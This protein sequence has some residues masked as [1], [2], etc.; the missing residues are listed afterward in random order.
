MKKIFASL[1]ILFLAVSV[2]GTTR[3]AQA[4]SAVWLVLP[5]RQ[6]KVDASVSN[7][8]GHLASD[9]AITVIVTLNKQADLSRVNGA[10]RAARQQG[11]LQALQA[12]SN[13]TQGQLKKLLD[14]RK[15]QGS[16][17]KYVSFWV[18]NGFSVTAT[19]DVINELAQQPDVYS[20]TS[21]DLQIIPTTYGN[22]EP[23]IS[24]V[25]AP[26]LWS[27]GYTGQGVVVASMDSGVDVSQPDLSGRWRGGS[28]SWYDPYNQH[29]TTPYDKSGHGTWTTGIMV[30]GNAGGT[31]V[32]VAPDAKWIAVK[33]FNDAGSSTTTAIHQGFQW[34]LDPDGNPAT[35]DAPDVVNNSW[36][37]ATPGCY[38]DFEPDLQS[39]RTAG[40]LPVF[41]A[42]NG[43]PSANTSY[44]PSNNP[45][46]FAVGA[47][48]NT[49]QIYGY[50][51]RGPSACGGSTGPY[52]EIVA[53]GVNIH[54]T[55]LGS[56]YYNDS[57]TSFAA[58]HVAGGL[59]LLLSAYPNLSA[60]DQA[61]ALMSSALDLGASGP[62]D[63]FGYGLMNLSAAL[64]WISSNPA[65]VNLALNKPVTVSTYQDS[66]HNGAMAVD[67]NQTTQWQTV[68]V[69]GKNPVKT[70]S[71]EVD[72]GSIQNVSRVVLKWD[73]YYATTYNVQVSTNRTTWSTV[74]NTSVG[75][76]GDNTATFNT[77]QARYVRMNS[78]VWNNSTNRNWL[79]E[80]EIYAG[81]STALADTPAP[82]SE[83][84]PTPS[85]TPAPANSVHVG[86]LDANPAANGARWN[87]TVIV[88][89]HDTFEAPLQGAVVSGAWSNGATGNGSC[90]TGADGTCSI[91][92]SALKTSVSNVT[93][94]V[95]NLSSGFSYQS[96][97]NHDPDGDSNGTVIVVS[98]P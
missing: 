6:H 87:A 14:S 7:A 51:S 39:L 34:L 70:E 93:F 61:Q 80:F 81:A 82:T 74:F 2:L 1:L 53:P 58:P 69:K 54:T 72:L 9:E 42:G 90:T 41:A 36:T 92:S 44:S 73:A 64:N 50:S 78:T 86:D 77:T 49:N 45:S 79:K 12:T 30:G 95:T 38:L 33:M 20:I 57:G 31:T 83:P 13:A 52:P 67:G 19:G 11:V 60:S 98:K 37:Y 23:N 29:P 43:G 17:K 4:G 68:R 22:P 27:Q 63:V 84:S 91:T 85:P 24:L 25:N 97:N 47:V 28:N 56:T 55:G 65:L 8:I 88:K 71:I 62:D 26:A 76:G 16:V 48:D 35:N 15:G 10:N 46:A 89:V 32:G 66:A 18:F 96:S 3:S 40:I 94:T 59:A 21:D 5:Q 75:S